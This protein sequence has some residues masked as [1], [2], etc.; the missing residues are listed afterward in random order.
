MKIALLFIACLLFLMG[1]SETTDSGAATRDLLLGKWELITGERNGKPTESLRGTYFEFYEDGR[2]ATNLPIRGGE[3]SRFVLEANLLIQT[4][5]EL[6]IQYQI[7]NLTAETLQLTTQLRGYN[8][9][10]SMA[11]GKTGT[12]SEVGVGH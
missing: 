1:C 12:L 7:E 2:M 11:K 5:G 6:T 3:D 4:A 10:F 8:F 9:R